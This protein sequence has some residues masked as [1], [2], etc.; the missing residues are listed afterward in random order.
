MTIDIRATVNTNLGRLISASISDDYLQNSGLIRCSGSCEVAG[1]VSP[2]AGS[3]VV[4]Q[5]TKNGVTRTLPRTLRVLSSFADPFRVTTKI[6]LGCKLTYLQDLT[7]QINWSAFDDEDDL[8]FSEEDQRIV[9]VPIRASA[10]ARKCLQELGIRASSMPLT[11]KFSISSFDF[12]GGYVNILSDLLLS[13]SYCGYLDATET[14]QI[15]SL[16]GS[17][18]SGPVLTA[19]DLIDVSGIGVGQLPGEAVTVSYSTLKLRNPNPSENEDDIAR[20]NWELETTEGPPQEVILTGTYLSES[21][22]GGNNEWEE[23]YRFSPSSRTETR[24]DEWDR[25]ISR[26]VTENSILADVNPDYISQMISIRRG[27][28]SGHSM[29]TKITV[30]TVNY[31]V[32][33]GGEKREGYDEVLSEITQVYESEAARMAS[34]SAQ[35]YTTIQGPLGDSYVPRS[36]SVFTSKIVFDL[37]ERTVITYETEPRNV[38]VRLN[39]GGVERV[40]NFPVTRTSTRREILYSRSARGQARISTLISED[41]EESY[42][43]IRTLSSQLVDQGVERRTVAGREAALQSRPGNAGN[44]LAEGGD[45]NNGYRTDSVAQ[46]ELAIGSPAAQRRIEFS[47]PYAPD[48]VFSKTGEGSNATFRSIPSDARIKA[49]NFGRAQNRLLL[50][51]RN[52]INIQ[53]SPERMPSVPFSPVSIVSRGLTALYR[54]NGTSWTMNASGILASTDALYWGTLGSS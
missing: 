3:K 26:E 17:A 45:P 9:I 39:S 32:P 31:R 22:F 30:T 13:E 28:L 16:N 11:N 8:G 40:G 25:V 20:R 42:G 14:L 27:A 1:L 43:Q 48:D 23:T 50:G 38:S 7:D 53:I 2:P 19:S 52:G 49:V 34:T 36:P 10:V 29:V 24:Y 18:G 15:F 21:P 12:S 47:M 37:S 5:Y 33:A 35:Y 44:A 41:P 4:F 46:L 54:T 51:N 6:E